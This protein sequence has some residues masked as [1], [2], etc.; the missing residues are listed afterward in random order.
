MELVI[1]TQLRKMQILWGVMGDCWARHLKWFCSNRIFIAFTFMGR[2]KHR[3][4]WFEDYTEKT[5][6][7]FLHLFN[8]L[9]WLMFS[10]CV[11]CIWHNVGSVFKPI[12]NILYAR[13]TV[14]FG[15]HLDFGSVIFTAMDLLLCLVT[16]R[17]SGTQL[18]GLDRHR[19]RIPFPVSTWY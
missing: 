13:G 4:K 16:N 17:L 10:N 15:E 3:I 19:Q 12:W 7:C 1:I 18:D 11:V 8:R 5:V 14:C 6:Y 2:G 9:H